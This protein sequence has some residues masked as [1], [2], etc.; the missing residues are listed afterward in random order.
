MS[1]CANYVFPSGRKKYLPQ[2]SV[3]GWHGGA[4]QELPE[5][6]LEVMLNQAWDQLP[7]SEK[8][9]NSIAKMRNMVLQSREEVIEQEADYFE[10]L[11]VDVISTVI[12]QKCDY[13]SNAPQTHNVTGWYFSIE[14]MIAL[15]ISNIVQEGGNWSPEASQFS[16]QLMAIELS[17]CGL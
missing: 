2:N 7:E 6:Q 17:K 8:K 3:L 12:G 5:D 10:K 16:R 13:Y 9:D 11:G 1:S 15:G 14:D 4:T